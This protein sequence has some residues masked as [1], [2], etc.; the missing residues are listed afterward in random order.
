[1]HKKKKMIW[2]ASLAGAVVFITPIVTA[3]YFA[4]EDGH[5]EART[6][7]GNLSDD[8]LRRSQATRAQV[9]AAIGTLS[10]H[11]SSMPCSSEQMDRMRATV[12]SSGYLQGMAYI[13]GD[14]L[15][16]T[17]LAPLSEPVA[18]GAP[19]R[20]R[21]RSTRTWA[22][23]Q[24][25]FVR[26]A[27]FN[28]S[29]RNGY[30]AI[31]SPELVMDIV[32][33]DSTLS[34]T[35]IDLSSN[36]V[37]RSRGVYRP[38]WMAGFQGVPMAFSD[39]EYFGVIKPSDTGETAVVVAEPIA[40]ADA[41]AYRL[42]WRLVP[43][44]LLIGLVLAGVVYLYARRRLSFKAELQSAL[45]NREFFLLYQPVIDLRSGACV[46][47]EALIRWHQHDGKII[48]PLVFI[49]AAEENGLIKDVTAQVMEMVA[50]DATD[51]IKEYPDTHIAI[52][53]SA[54]DLHA[55]E[56]EKRLQDLLKRAGA[57]S[58][59]IV[60][61]ATERGLMFP[62]K[63]RGMLVA[64]RSQGFKVAIDDFGTGNS[65][66]SYL[67]T[68]DL[69][70]IKIDKMFVDALGTDDATSRVTFHI[71]EMARSLGLQMIA[72]GVETE[73]Q[74]DILRQAGVQFAQGWVFGKPMSMPA[75][76]EFI[77]KRNGTAPAQA[78]T[79]SPVT[80]SRMPFGST[81][82]ALPTRTPKPV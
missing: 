29:E 15:M 71:I 78:R 31:L 25:P 21:A 8:V 28:I 11:P 20:I 54:E 58:K 53:V 16:C 77:K 80:A 68:Y 76:A 48:S 74:H 61:E 82:G 7:L 38:Q 52:N 9:D 24:L 60:I 14:Y 66:L 72:E 6:Q 22:S 33:P 17:T 37:V 19:S 63:A 69:D 30:A 49:A 3:F 57:T 42:A 64:V 47:A 44:G 12:A 73:I 13:Q 39:G 18:L 81:P 59:N 26:D 4:W 51:L 5:N 79:S 56:T 43:L 55:P 41:L 46:G 23:V 65:S 27:A 1:M 32:G 2:A 34:L 62:E 35:Q 75:L 36:S 10:A 45:A 67:A 50:R 40:Q 70:F